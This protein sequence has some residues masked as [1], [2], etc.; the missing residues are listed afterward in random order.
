MSGQIPFEDFSLSTDIPDFP[1][2]WFNALKWGL[3]DQ[4]AYEY[5]VGLAERSMIT[6]KALY[7]KTQALS[8]GGEEG[9]L[10]IQPQP[11]WSPESY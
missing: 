7:H 2:Y 3:A 11:S 5:G 9:S 10:K 1:S 8:F 6:K 4:L